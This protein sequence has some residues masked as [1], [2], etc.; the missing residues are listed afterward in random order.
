MRLIGELHK[1]MRALL[2]SICILLLASSCVKNNPDPTWIVIEKWT[3]EANPN[4]VDEPES[5]HHNLT[6][7]WVYVDNKLMGVF[8]LPVK[9]PVL[10]EGSKEIRIYPAIKNNGISATKKIYPFMEVYGATID[11]LKNE[12]VT[13]SPV[14]RYKDATKFWDE[15]FEDSSPQIIN[16]STSLVT[17]QRVADPSI[18]VS[19]I[20]GEHFGR[21]T[22]TAAN[23]VYSASTTANA[24]GV[25]NMP[26][27]SGKD[28]YLEIDYH[29][30]N[31]IT[32]GLLAISSDSEK[33]NPN[34]QINAQDA[35]GIQWK[36]IYIQLDEVVSFST[37][38][39]RFEI[40]L[41][42]VLDTG[43]TE[44]EINIDNIKAVY[45]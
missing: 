16:S 41:N 22:L 4:I 36:K 40:T 37:T 12:T 1:T 17:I 45:F 21:I 19:S 33:D 29:T 39:N 44:G 35:S 2:Y 25:L 13:I 27:P 18:L 3:V 5:L 6:E 11:M 8:E 15:D 7:A 32:T 24:N 31:N 14:T 30:T 38:A 20:N 28:V 34:V 23:N 10:T 43:E 42:A 9:I 26:L